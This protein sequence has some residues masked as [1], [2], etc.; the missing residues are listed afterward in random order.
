MLEHLGEALTVFVGAWRF[1]LSPSYRER[2]LAEWREALPTLS[3]KAVI[4][5]EIIAATAI[6]VLL[7]LWLISLVVAW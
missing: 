2:K 6:G 4:A 3:G 7:P 1:L 5:S